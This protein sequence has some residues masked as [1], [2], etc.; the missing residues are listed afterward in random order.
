VVEAYS[1]PAGSMEPTILIGDH[2]FVD[3]FAYALRSPLSGAALVHRRDPVRGELIVFLYPDD[4]SRSFLKRVVGLPG[5][6]V[7]VRGP[8][9]LVDGRRLEEPYANRWREPDATDDWGPAVVPARHLF[10][11]GDARDNSRD[12]RH[13]GFVPMEDVLGEAALV[14]LSISHA[15]GEAPTLLAPQNIRWSRI[16]RVLR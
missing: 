6:T 12:S 9:V 8:D 10:V 13:H 1:I 3:K 5:E 11:L 14:Y 2:L 15:R 4:R 7:E 16:G